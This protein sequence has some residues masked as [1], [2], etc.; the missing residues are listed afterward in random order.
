MTITKS[1][2]F[3]LAE[4]EISP[5]AAPA[6][7]RRRLEKPVTEAD[8]AR[9]KV[10]ERTT[11]VM[12][13]AIYG[14]KTAQRRLTEAI[15][16]SDLVRWA[17]GAALDRQIER[18]YPAIPAQWG[19]FF[20]PTTVRNFKPKSIAQLH[21]GT[22]HLRDI[23]ELTRYPMAKGSS[24]GEYFIQVGKT[25]LRY[26]W[27]WEAMLNDDLDQLMAVV[28]QFPQYA[29]NTE[30]MKALS[31]MYNLTTGAP[32][33]A[34]FNATNKNLGTMVL[35]RTNL[36]RVDRF[37][38]TKRDPD[39]G[40]IIV[41]QSKMLVVG[42]ALELVA[43]SLLEATQI[44][45]TLADGSK[46]T[47]S[48][49]LAGKFELVVDEKRPGTSWMVIPKPGTAARQPFWFAKLVGYETPDLRYRNN[50]GRALGG[51]DLAP[52]EGSFDD[53][54]IEYRVRHVMGVATGDPTLTYASDNTGGTT[55]PTG[56]PTA[57]DVAAMLS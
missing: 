22:D 14:D 8:R 19:K 11:S 12:R 25:G 47:R 44:E 38:S 50:Q 43:R 53:D 39:L 16:T 31:L 3:E 2:P 51:G 27:S 37:L 42:P 9:V 6:L 46:I 20:T 33:T 17:T 13:D 7:M 49:P 4:S 26:G 55:E 21:D 1:D 48:N 52:S 24:L 10:V 54:S 36:L 29:V 41:F 34:F 35:N 18:T 5:M 30:D 57:A 32:A 45:T 40:G 56:M 28:R 23:P 15:S